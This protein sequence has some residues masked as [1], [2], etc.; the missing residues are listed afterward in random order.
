MF[1]RRQIAPFTCLGRRRPA[2]LIGGFQIGPL[3]EDAEETLRGG[4]D[5]GAVRI[6]YSAP[7]NDQISWHCDILLMAAH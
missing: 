3:M 5:E 6:A 4:S 7:V 2:L 1:Q